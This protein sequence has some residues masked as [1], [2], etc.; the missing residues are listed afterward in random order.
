MTTIKTIVVDF[1]KEFK[2]NNVTPNG[3]KCV[4]G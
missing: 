1:W 3:V 4:D 2:Q